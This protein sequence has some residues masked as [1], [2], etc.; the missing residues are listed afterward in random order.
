MFEICVGVNDAGQRLDKFLLKTLNNCPKSLL[1]RAHRQNKIKCNKKKL[2]LDYFICK[3]DLLNIYL[4]D[5][6]MPTQRKTHAAPPLDPSWIVYE[7]NLV[8]IVNKPFGISA[9]SE[10]PGVPNLQDMAISYL[11]SSGSFIVDKENSFTPSFA[12]RLDRNTAGLMILGKTAPSLRELNALIRHGNTQ[13]YYSC[14]VKGTMPKQHDILTGYLLKDKG[15]NRA[16]IVSNP[17]PCSK[18]VKTEYWVQQHAD[19]V[20]Q[21]KILLHT[22]RSHQIRAQ[23][24]HIGH[25]LLGD[26]K[27]GGQW[28]NYRHQ[29]LCA[30]KLILMPPK[31]TLLYTLPTK[32]FTITPYYQ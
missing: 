4:P 11:Q 22:G 29:A 19:S 3:G 30:Y 28:E 1:Y 32:I 21:L 31:D 10:K 27:Y 5:K 25:P 14:L 9:H 2:P 18:F 16:K 7:D 6:F 20:T 15:A 17:L 13:K 23:L 12:N 24:S 26:K 8:L